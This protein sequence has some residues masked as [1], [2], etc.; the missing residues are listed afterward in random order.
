MNNYHYG[1]IKNQ[2][3]SY[4]FHSYYDNRC[5]GDCRGCWF[6]Y[7]IR[8][9]WPTWT[10]K[11]GENHDALVHG[12][13]QSILEAKTV[14]PQVRSVATIYNISMFSVIGKHLQFKWL[15]GVVILTATWR[16]TE[17]CTHRHLHIFTRA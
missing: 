17:S 11:L 4:I 15:V 1:C 8:V 5:L 16:S 14:E 2:R 10:C 7:L 13:K 9:L 6:A 3:Y 12:W